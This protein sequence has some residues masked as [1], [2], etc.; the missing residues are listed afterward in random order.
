M[1]RRLLGLVVVMV[2]SSAAVSGCSGTTQEA[3]ERD[4]KAVAQ[5]LSDA[6]SAAQAALL[7][8]QTPRENITSPYRRQVVADAEEGFDSAVSTFE[9]RQP[10]DTASSNALD[11]RSRALLDRTGSDLRALRIA[12]E[13]GDQDQ[14]TDARDALATSVEQ[15]SKASDELS[16]S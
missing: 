6:N 4:T 10:P 13:R 8:V 5:S 16:A 2:L 14:I 3:E 9:A 7:A 11:D 1:A 15:L 12:V